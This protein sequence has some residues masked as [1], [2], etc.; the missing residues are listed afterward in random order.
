MQVNGTS[1][2]R[3][4]IEHPEYASRPEDIERMGKLG[5]TAS[6]QVPGIEIASSRALR[7]TIPTIVITHRSEARCSPSAGRCPRLRAAARRVAR[8]LPPM[9][10]MSRLESDDEDSRFIIIDTLTRHIEP[11][12]A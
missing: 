5:I 4:R 12:Q 1:G 2:K 10:M 11:D 7:S 6:M 8:C 9:A 3:H